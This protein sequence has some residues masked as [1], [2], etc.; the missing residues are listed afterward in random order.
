MVQNKIKKKKKRVS[1]KGWWYGGL[2]SIGFFC[3]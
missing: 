1:Y 3:D 2:K